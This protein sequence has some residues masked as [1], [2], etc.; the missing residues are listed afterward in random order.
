MVWW[1]VVSKSNKSTPW[2]INR[3]I[4]RNAHHTPK[5][6][7]QSKLSNKPDPFQRTSKYMFTETLNGFHRCNNGYMK[8]TYT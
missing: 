8:V 7:V 4:D 3:R 5:R 1:Y 2:T 6:K